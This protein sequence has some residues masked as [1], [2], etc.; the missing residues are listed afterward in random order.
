MKNK[1]EPYKMETILGIC[2][3]DFV[4]VAADTTQA[5]SVIVMK[6][7][8]NKLHKI[9]DNLVMAT[10]GE[11]GDTEQFTEFISKNIA[12]YKMH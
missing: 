12:L 6:G 9:T 11:S 2:G 4:M 10:I 3:L 7:G 1:L 5:Q 8:E